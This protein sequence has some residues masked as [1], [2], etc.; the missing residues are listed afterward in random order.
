MGPIAKSLIIIGCVF[1]ISGLIWHF[2]DG[3][4]PF[5]RLPGDIRIEN[6]H[7]KIYIPLTSMLIVSAI[8]SILSYFIKK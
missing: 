3:K 7:T 1:I 6:E 8:L 4:I 2:S 5:G